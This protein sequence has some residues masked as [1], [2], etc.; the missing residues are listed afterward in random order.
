MEV[1]LVL[2]GFTSPEGVFP[3]EIRV[4]LDGFPLLPL[5]FEVSV[6]ELIVETNLA[7]V[8]KTRAKIHPVDARPQA[9]DRC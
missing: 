2:P 5:E 8:R 9:H 4:A 3:F 6:L 1:F 7:G